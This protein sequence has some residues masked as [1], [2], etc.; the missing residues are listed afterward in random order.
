[1]S[2][3]IPRQ[4]RPRRSRTYKDVLQEHEEELQEPEIELANQDNRI[5]NLQAQIHQLQLQQAPT[6]TEDPAPS[7]IVDL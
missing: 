7:D 1:M 4:L 2:S 6:P 3:Q 5:A